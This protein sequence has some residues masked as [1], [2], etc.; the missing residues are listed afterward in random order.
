MAM[1]VD[2]RIVQDWLDR[3]G[4]ALVAGDAS[5]AASAFGEE[6]YWRD[7]V[8]FTWN[9]R[10]MEGRG[11]IAAMLKAQLPSIEPMAFAIS[12]AVQRSGDV[13]EAWFDFETRLARGRGH[14]RL[15]DGLGFTFLTTMTE[16]KG[17]EERRGKTRDNGVTHGA[18][19]GRT[20]WLEQKTAEESLLGADEQ[21]F[22]V[23][24]GGG[25]GGIA[26]GARLKC[27][28]VPTI[29]LEKN[30]RAG[31][32]WRNRYRS[33]VLHDPV[34][35]DHLPYI[36]FPEHWPVFTPKDKMGDWLEMYTKVMELN[37][38]SS[39]EC[40]K[41]SY[42]S[43]AK[44]WTLDVLRNG[45]ET[46]LKPR[47][48]VFATGSY[49]PP[50]QIAIPGQDIFRGEQYHSARHVTATA[51][52]G[53]R[54]IVIG[55]NSSAH[56][57]CADFWE[58]DAD[59]TMIQRTPT[60]VVRSETM[61]ALA[62]EGLY[63]E[64]AVKN[65]IGVEQADLIFAATPFRLMAVGQVPLYAEIAKRD[66]D[67]LRRLNQAGFRTDFG[68][69]Q[70]GLLMKALRTG[71]GYYLDVGASELIASGAVK[72]RSG[73]EVARLTARSAILTDGSELPADVIV[74]ATGYL[75]MNEW[76]ARIVSRQAADLIGPNWGYGSGTRG[77]PGPWQGELRNMWKPL[78]HEALWFHGG[79]LH[80]SRHYSLYVALQLKARL[81]GLPT[82]VY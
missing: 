10:T 70:S 71:S 47:Q 19:K 17:H 79:N 3:L 13:L 9:I 49:G 18:V 32:S 34:W 21:P 41:A 77:D 65:G 4:H 11:A 53:K 48:L 1:A 55:A 78:K 22:C 14:L 23:V 63:S 20:T 12:G 60:T 82:P 64:N 38:W 37:Y 44:E 2:T 5:A 69:D 31:D 54:C 26:L 40:R 59:V 25:Q 68:A 8:S 46:T 67:L 75:P 51:Y 43:D 66:A 50:R 80:L 74:Y 72:V 56:D 76:V 6:C 57:I 24:I 28:G 58:H 27:L 7:L 61:M 39:A 62:F 16:L 33:L 15:K 35:Y 52:R 30:A 42:D 81:V 73:V 29:I 36:P 45:R